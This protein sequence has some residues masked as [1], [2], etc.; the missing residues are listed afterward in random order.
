MTKAD[1]NKVI[2]TA[3]FPPGAGPGQSLWKRLL[4]CT[5]LAPVNMRRSLPPT[6]TRADTGSVLITQTLICPAR[7]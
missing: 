3:G 5:L 4:A 7:Q 6:A 1:V 2:P